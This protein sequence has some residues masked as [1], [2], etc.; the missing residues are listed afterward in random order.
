MNINNNLSIDDTIDD[1]ALL[2]FYWNYFELHSNQ[3]MQMINFYITIEV[4]LFG[5][6]FTLLNLQNRIFWAEYINAFAISFISV[7]FMGLDYRTKKMIQWCED[8]IKNLENKY[9]NKFGQEFMLINK[10]EIPTDSQTVRLTYSRWFYLQFCVIGL[11]G[12]VCLMMLLL[13]RI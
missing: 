2:D 5:G 9:E 10:S 4:V 8:C 11:C 6:F 13:G 12:I 3:R 1:K 7:I